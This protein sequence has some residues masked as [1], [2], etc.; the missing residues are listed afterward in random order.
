[1]N[2]L[3]GCMTDCMDGMNAWVGGWIDWKDGRMR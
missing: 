3:D 2:E 1:M